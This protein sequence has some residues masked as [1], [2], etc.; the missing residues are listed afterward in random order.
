MNR[1]KSRK[2]NKN[3]ERGVIMHKT[4]VVIGVVSGSVS[5]ILWVVLHFFNPYSAEVSE[6]LPF[7]QTIV[8]LLLPA[9]LA[10][11]ATLTRQRIFLFIAFLWSLPISFYFMLTTSLFSFFAVTCIGYLLSFL[12]IKNNSLEKT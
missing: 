5:I 6:I 2:L 7:R 8:T 4:G 10:V 9:I 12:L 1:E 3:E 11:V